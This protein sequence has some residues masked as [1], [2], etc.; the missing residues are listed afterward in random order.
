MRCVNTA[1]KS[2]AALAL[3]ATTLFAQSADPDLQRIR[4]DIARLKQ[5]LSDVRKQAQSVEAE[6]EAAD[7]ELGIR[8]RELEITIDTHSR[9]EAERSAI[10]AQIADLIP[11]IDR[12]KKSLG[13]RLVALYRLGGLSYVRMFLSVGEQKDPSAAMSML[14]FL[15]T[16][17]ARMI[18]RFKESRRELAIRN[19]QLAERQQQ[20]VAAVKLIEE[21]R[22]SVAAAV[23][24]KERLLARLRKEETGSEVQIAELEE[25][26]RRLER[27]VAVLSSQQPE[28]M[29]AQDVRS[30]RGALAWPVEG[31]V[32]ESFGR[33]RNPKF[34]TYTTNNGLKIEAEP[35]APVRA[36]FQGTV[37]FSQ[38]FRGY[39]NLIILDHGNRVFSLYGNLNGPT[40]AAGDRITTGQTI[41]GVG[42][43]EEAE[44]GYLYFE[45]RQ[46][47]RPED[48]KGWLR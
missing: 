48:P 12:Q 45:I 11:R 4:N 30:F 33:Q 16:H 7:L 23:A 5:R 10:A 3:V 41:A 9:L 31:K 44:S 42:E 35:R 6:V 46:D 29:A 47:N 21:Q 27:L 36:V 34:A 19:E 32:I 20:L 18:N 43:A 37:L 39:G 28:A 40:V 15:V 26:A 22:K 24:Q 25:K 2:L 14:S 1:R 13:K 17:D 38:W 8:T